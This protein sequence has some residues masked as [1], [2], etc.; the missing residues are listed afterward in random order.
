MPKT[1]TLD[2]R[3]SG[4]KHRSFEDLCD[5]F[6]KQSLRYLVDQL[7]CLA[8]NES[9]PYPNPNLRRAINAVI[10]EKKDNN[11]VLAT[12]PKPSRILPAMDESITYE[13]QKCGGKGQTILV[14]IAKEVLE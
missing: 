2:A 13:R 10:A 3:R 6:R 12:K 5:T 14:P 11:E 7:S 9:L 1:M 4:M 8:Y